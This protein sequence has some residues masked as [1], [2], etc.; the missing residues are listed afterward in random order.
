MFYR[1]GEGIRADKSRRR[2]DKVEKKET[3]GGSDIEM[4][5]EVTTGS[6]RKIFF[7]F[8]KKNVIFTLVVGKS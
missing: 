7:F 4:A 3:K 6:G 1:F 8:N 5:L 2:L